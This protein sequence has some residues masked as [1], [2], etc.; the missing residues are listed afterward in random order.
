[1]LSTV[2]LVLL[3]LL[4]ILVLIECIV[5]FFLRIFVCCFELCRSN[6]LFLL[7]QKFSAGSIREHNT[8][9]LSVDVVDVLV[10]P[11]IV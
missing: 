8:V 1:M 7:L 6:V 2:V 4:A 10:S 9:L 3:F 5:L 11:L